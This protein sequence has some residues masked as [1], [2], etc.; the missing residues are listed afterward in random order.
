M[1]IK[2][3]RKILRSSFQIAALLAGGYLAL[4][5]PAGSQ[6]PANSTLAQRPGKS[7][8]VAAGE[9]E[10]ASRIN[11]WTVGLAGGPIEGAFIWFAADLG[12]ALN[13]GD[14]LRILPIITSGAGDNVKDLVY[15]KGIDVALTNTDVLEHIRRTANISN[16]NNRIHYISPLFTT[17]FHVYARAD[18]KTLADLAGKKVGMHTPGG[19]ASISGP[20]IFDR[21]GIP[22]EAVFVNNSVGYEKLKSGEFAAIVHMVAKPNDLF[23][24][25]KADPG[26]HFLPVPYSNKTEDLYLPSKITSEDYP[27]LIPAGEKIDT[28]AVTTVLAVFNWSKSSD[29]FRR[30]A[31]FIDT[32]AQRIEKLQKP[33]F[34]PKWKEVNLAG[35]V[36][37]WTRYWY[38]DEL[39]TRMAAAAAQKASLPAGVEPDGALQ[40]TL[41]RE[42]ID[43]SRQRQQRGVKAADAID[44][45]AEFRAFLDWR[46]QRAPQ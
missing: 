11:N 9:G 10:E 46:K 7:R 28:L 12:T 18:I 37:G 42:F 43:W 25:I 35:K 16:L 26:Y 39:L 8:A 14:N 41:F 3:R 33:P 19:A 23:K 15:L 40:E 22:V 36:P 17:D 45:Q 38:A 2:T 20:I 21:L 44:R 29:R 27:H 5:S 30:V 34:N 32:F 6:G 4:T 31:R 24:K 1:L 13:D